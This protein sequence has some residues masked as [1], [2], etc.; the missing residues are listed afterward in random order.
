MR[1]GIWVGILLLGLVVVVPAW[2]QVTQRFQVG[3]SPTALIYAGDLTPSD[4]RL[5]RVSA[6]FNASLQF[7]LPKLFTPQLNIGV[8]RL[9]AQDRTLGPAD[10]VQPN[11]FV[12]TRLIHASF[13]L[14]LR[15]MRRSRFRPHAGVGI[16]L[17]SYRP[18]D[19]I[20]EN[21]A[22]QPNTRAPG[23]EYGGI[24]GVLPLNVGCTYKINDLFAVGFDYTRQV[25]FTDYLDN[26]GALGTDNRNDRLHE[27]RFTVYFSPT[28]KKRYGRGAN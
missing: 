22:D 17:L 28:Y 10:G 20:G 7:D 1:Y 27:L 12:S 18:Q 2:G 16:G 13:V 5:H 9:R 11:T 3:V 15:L 4:E 6:G 8:A 26:I 19:E 21:L 14:R 23:E 24:T 25:V